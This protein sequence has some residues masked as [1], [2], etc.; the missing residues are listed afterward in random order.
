[1]KLTANLHLVPR[2]RMCGA[3]HPLPQFV[4]M[5]WCLAKHRDNIL[6][7]GRLVLDYRHGRKFFSSSQN[8]DPPNLLCNKYS[9][10]RSKAAEA[11]SWKL[12]SISWWRSDEWIVTSIL[13]YI[14]IMW[15][16]STGTTAFLYA[17]VNMTSR[18]K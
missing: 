9:Y 17:L 5:P 16:L 1:M 4:F 3:V 12:T 15:C 11:W 13:S 14:F 6:Q 10:R 2:S 18:N 8:G 7:P